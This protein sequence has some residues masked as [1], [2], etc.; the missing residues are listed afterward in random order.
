MADSKC[1][2]EECPRR[3]VCRG[4]CNKHYERWRLRGTTDD[5]VRPPV[6]DLPGERWLPVPGHEG[7]YE[8]SNMGRLLGLPRTCTCAHLGGLLN[9]QPNPLGY[10]FAD[11]KVPGRPERP[12][13]IH[14]LVAEAFIGP[15]PPGME[16]LH[17]PNG[18]GDNRVS[19]LRYGTHL[20]NKQDELRDGTRARGERHGNS[21]LTAEIVIECRRRRASGETVESIARDVGIRQPAMSNA[22]TGKTWTH[23]PGALPPSRG[24]RRPKVPDANAA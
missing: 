12:V 7:Y 24:P 4:W 8:V 14:R 6:V 21:K 11:L 18:P 13:G 5:P 10:F 2:V 16:V 20:E 1:A 23:V 17:G 19:E 3:A 9:P 22:L 15:C